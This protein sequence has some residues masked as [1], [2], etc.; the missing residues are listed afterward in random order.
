MS[1]EY[2]EASTCDLLVYLLCLDECEIQSFYDR[3][4][5][6][7]TSEVFTDSELKRPAPRR[8]SG[9]VSGGRI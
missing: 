3:F 8:V 9:E 6:H 4:Q 2:G 5:G 7:F 1:G